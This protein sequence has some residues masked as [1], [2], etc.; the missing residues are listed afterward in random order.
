[1]NR[2]GQRMLKISAGLFG[3]YLLSTAVHLAMARIPLIGLNLLVSGAFVGFFL[4][5]ILM[6][7]AFLAKNGWH[8]WGIYLLLTVVMLLI[9]FQ[10]G[11]L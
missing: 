5:T 11:P 1:M 8:V 10:G 7:L 2:P 6:V 9:A 3:G 4:W